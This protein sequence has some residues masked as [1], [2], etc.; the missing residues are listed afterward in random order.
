MNKWL[1]LIFVIFCLCYLTTFAQEEVEEDHALSL[2]G[3]G[4][5]GGGGDGGEGQGR[6]GRGRG[7]RLGGR[8][9]KNGLRGR[10]Q[11]PERLALKAWAESLREEDYSFDY[12]KTAFHSS[13]ASDFFHG[14]AK[15]ISEVFREA[16][17]KVNFALVG[18]CDGN[19]D[20]TIKKLYI[21]NSHWRGVFVE[22][23]SINVRDLIKFLA[24]KNIGHR[25]LVLRGAATLECAEPTIKVERPLYEEKNASIPHW[26]RRQIGSVLPA[27]RDHARREWTIEEVRCLT[28]K[29]I[30]TEWS[31][32]TTSAT[33]TAAAQTGYFAGE[34]P[35]ISP[36]QQRQASEA[37]HTVNKL[38]RPHILKIDVEGH[39][40]EVLMSFFRW[41]TPTHDLPLIVEF[42]AKS[43]AK[44]YPKARER[45]ESLG[46]VV[47]PFGQDGFAILP[48]Q[49][50]LESIQSLDPAHGIPGDLEPDV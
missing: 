35:S 25:S 40:F 30:L 12:W 5:G 22:P 34:S 46:Y 28:A 15:K 8:R 1:L 39:D 27:H 3:E 14:Y 50:V 2:G 18:A 16:G 43:I 21:P 4:G 9:R 10:K 33:G 44:N 26:L 20:K 42:E 45:L 24:E 38:R 19:G 6:G 13:S 48:A 29:D 31:L 47:S 41:D 37:L 7:K 17:A 49:K 36:E 11:S 23:M 32:A